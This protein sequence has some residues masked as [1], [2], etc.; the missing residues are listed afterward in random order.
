[1]E[2]RFCVCKTKN[3]PT[4]IY[5]NTFARLSNLKSQ[6][7]GKNDRDVGVHSINVKDLKSK[8]ECHSHIQ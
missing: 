3:R 4:A 8:K 1:M 6:T 7:E 2:I 5:F